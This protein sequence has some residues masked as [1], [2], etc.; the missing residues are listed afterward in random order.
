MKKFFWKFL[1]INIFLLFY[2]WAIN[3]I[4]KY[5]FYLE[6]TKNYVKFFNNEAKIKELKSGHIVAKEN[7]L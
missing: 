7:L 5:N 4:N 1:L 3:R 2:R 6:F